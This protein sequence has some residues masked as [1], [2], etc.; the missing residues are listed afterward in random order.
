LI[1]YAAIPVLALVIILSAC[2]SSTPTPTSTPAATTPS[3]DISKIPG[4]TMTT[5]ET[6][7]NIVSALNLFEF[8]RGCPK[9]K[10]ANVEIT[11]QQKENNGPW[12][13]RWTIDRCGT[14]V[15]YILIFTPDPKAGGAAFSIEPEKKQTVIPEP[16]PKP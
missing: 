3:F 9:P 10:I 12:T 6:Q 1:K 2:N 15:A 14:A 13:E 16:A 7:K 11:Q 5:A 8:G 4:N